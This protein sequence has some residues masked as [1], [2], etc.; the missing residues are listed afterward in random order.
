MG[1][2]RWRRALDTCFRCALLVCGVQNDEENESNDHPREHEVIWRS[3]HVACHDVKAVVGQVAQAPTR[4]AGNRMRVLA[5]RGS[6]KRLSSIY[7]TCFSP[8]LDN[9]ATPALRPFS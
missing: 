8:L 6:G 4:D 2:S 9:M 3:M 1:R 7:I 5:K